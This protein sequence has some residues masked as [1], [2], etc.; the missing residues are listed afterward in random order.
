MPREIHTALMRRKLSP[1]RRSADAAP[2]AVDALVRLEFPRAADD[3][4]ALSIDVRAMASR[5]ME[6][7]AVIEALSESDLIFLMEDSAGAHGL[8]VLDAGLVA[9]LIEV[10]LTGRVSPAKTKPR[11]ATRTDAVVVSDMVDRWIA[12]AKDGAEEGGFGEAL[13][14]SGY[15]RT[16]T[17]MDL[18]AAALTLDPG[19]YEMLRIVMS[20]DGAKEGVLSFFLPPKYG[21]AALDEADQKDLLRAQLLHLPAEM[22]AVLTRIN[23]PLSKVMSFAEGET[24]EVPRGALQALRLESPRGRKITNARLGHLD[25]FRA[26]RLQGA[27]ATALPKAAGVAALSAP[28]SSAVDRLPDLEIDP[29][30]TGAGVAGITDTADFG[31]LPDL[32]PLDDLPDLPDLSDLPE[33]PDIPGLP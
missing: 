16:N 23:L 3:L 25:G 4:L 14:L 2:G 22:D 26:V 5:R 1:K 24:F 15:I 30:A 29:P 18:R 21:A 31:A 10:Q 7:A 27:E 28:K 19:A 20:L 13:T 17:T 11:P 6:E 32:P 12:A 8:C 33:L 9:G